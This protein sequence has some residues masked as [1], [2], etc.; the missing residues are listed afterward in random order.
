MTETQTADPTTE[1]PVRAK[2]APRTDLH[3]RM[4]S[5]DVKVNRLETREAKLLNEL[6]AV[7]DELD[8]ARVA[9]SMCMDE[10]QSRIDS[11]RGKGNE[12]TDTPVAAGTGEV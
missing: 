1:K 4:K 5:A 10:M 9:Q 11:A 12:A 8:V 3:S 6:E 2:R 7:R